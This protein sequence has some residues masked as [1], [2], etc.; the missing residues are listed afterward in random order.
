MLPRI[1][2]EASRMATISQQT[3]YSLSGLYNWQTHRLDNGPLVSAVKLKNKAVTTVRI[4]VARLCV[5]G[6]WG[7]CRYN[8]GGKS[9]RVK[10]L[11][12]GHWY[13]RVEKVVKDPIVMHG[14]TWRCWVP[15]SST[16]IN[17][18]VDLSASSLHRY[19]LML[20]LVVTIG[21][22]RIKA[23]SLRKASMMLSRTI[24]NLGFMQTR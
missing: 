4:G 13:M 12:F 19:S 8:P 18:L 22:S 6:S 14:P 20:G 10:R 5:C 16:R 3:A 15:R 21:P 11:F 9:G 2:P 24:S 23:V 17:V 7:K 1:D